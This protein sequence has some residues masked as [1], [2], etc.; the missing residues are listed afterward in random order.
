[1]EMNIS[2]HQTY[3][4]NITAAMWFFPAVGVTNMKEEGSGTL[5]LQH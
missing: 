5:A 2:F 3:F 1:M 4:Q